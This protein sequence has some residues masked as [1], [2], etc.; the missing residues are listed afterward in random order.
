MKLNKTL[1]IAALMAGSLFSA[2]TLLAQDAPKDKPPG[3][4][5]S[6][7]GP[8]GPGGPAV[9]RPMLT[10]EAVSKQLS[11]TDEQ[12]PKVKPIIDD[13]IQKMTDMRKDTAMAPADRRTKMKEIRDAATAKLKDI[14]TAEQLATWEKM[15][16]RR[17]GAGAGAP[18]P[19][20][21][22]GADAKAKDPA[23]PKN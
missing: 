9:R 14:L 13:Y 15:G 21:G 4:Q 5:G 6:P 8:G 3:D 12:K 20:A 23:P 19:A 22:A 11:L 17:P 16:A 10:F 18:P 1:M 2:G 7:G